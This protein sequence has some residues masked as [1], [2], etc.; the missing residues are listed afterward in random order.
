VLSE[1]QLTL[2]KIPEYLKNLPVK[3]NNN[4]TKREEMDI[5]EQKIVAFFKKYKNNSFEKTYV[6]DSTFIEIEGLIEKGNFDTDKFLDFSEQLQ[7]LQKRNYLQFHKRIYRYGYQYGRKSFRNIPPLQ[8][9]LDT[10]H[11]LCEFFKKGYSI[12]D[13]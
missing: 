2:Q 6:P 5:Y 1:H 4:I 7:S 9:K 11:S 10:L 12:Q 3:S 13:L 8:K